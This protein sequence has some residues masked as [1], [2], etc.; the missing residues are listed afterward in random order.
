M[1]PTSLLLLLALGSWSALDTTSVGQFM[2]SR[3]LVAGT[4]AGWILG[5]PAT[6]LLVGGLLEG[7]HL[8]DLPSGG[9][10]LPEPGPAAVAGVVAAVALGGGGGVALGVALAVVMGV[11]GGLSMEGVRALNA[12][13]SVVRDGDG[14]R[15]RSRP[16]RHLT[17]VAL[18]GVRG[19]FLTGAGVALALALPEGL[20]A[21]WPLDPVRTA[22]F[23]ALPG[24]L[25]AGI[26]VRT[27]N[28]GRV[29]TTL[30]FGAGVGGGLLLGGM[31]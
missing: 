15:V 18:D 7:V 31:G 8:A 16:E 4:L 12:R 17:C 30:L 6:G 24:V 28:V 25:A 21:R 13:V 20:A 11:V 14:G 2:V 9:A 26:L 19:L 3:P 5:D 10:R 1:E 27:W 29:G 22:G 23:L